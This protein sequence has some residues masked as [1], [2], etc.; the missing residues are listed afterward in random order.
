MSE[1]LERFAGA[2]T[3]VFFDALDVFLAA[4]DVFFDAFLVRHADTHPGQMSPRGT[5]RQDG[6]VIVSFSVRSAVLLSLF[7]KAPRSV[8]EKKQC[9]KQRR[10]MKPLQVTHSIETWSNRPSPRICG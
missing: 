7:S 9:G 5:P 1:T 4:L 8:F 10:Q 3:V 2:F 6:A